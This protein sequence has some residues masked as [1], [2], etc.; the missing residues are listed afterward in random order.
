MSNLSMYLL[1]QLTIFD[2]L[3]SYQ[4]GAYKVPC[5]GMTSD[6]NN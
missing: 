4:V 5:A 6:F 2:I 3:S 1:N